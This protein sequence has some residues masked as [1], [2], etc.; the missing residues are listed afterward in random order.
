MLLRRL[1]AIVAGVCFVVPLAG[2][3]ADDVAPSDPFW[4]LIHDDAF[5]AELKLTA[6]QRKELRAILD[7]LDLQGFPLR[8]K[9]AAE[10]T[11]G[12]ARLAA[13]AKAALSKVLKP[14]QLQ[15]IE[16]IGVRSQGT[17]SLLRDDV[18]GKLKL[19]DQQRTEI[20]DVVR[21]T[22]EDKAKVQ[23]ELLAAKIA[24]AQA[25]QEVQR[26]NV[27]QRDKINGLLTSEQKSRLPALLGDDFDTSKLGNTRF[28]APEL[29]GDSAAWLNSPPLASESLRGRVVVVHYFAFGCINC[30]HNYPTYREWQDEL[31]GKNVQIIG[32]H[33]PE[34]KSEHNVETLKGK[35]K[36]EELRFPVIVDNELANWNAWGN[37]MWPSV[38]ILDKQGYLRTFWAGELKWQGATGDK[39]MRQKI[40]QL[41]A[42]K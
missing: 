9:S 24:A 26:L 19:T 38:Y 12:F 3:A 1:L 20:R 35:L 4:N 32:I 34:T 39:Q 14:L 18:A 7:P 29:V 36:A 37:G 13:E 33:T 22:R 40:E 21:R 28:K 8:N 6:S 17:E 30:I 27:A 11:E 25:E 10:A 31:A 23:K 5:L 41:L 15:R 16:Q 42:E 2:I